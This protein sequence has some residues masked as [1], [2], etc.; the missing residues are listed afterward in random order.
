[1]IDDGASACITIDLKDFVGRSCRINQ[2]IKGV[3]GHAQATHRGT[4]Q[5]KIED[6]SG[7]VHSI[8]I[9]GT[10]Y[11]AGMPNQIFSPQHFAQVANDHNPK[12]EG[13]RSITNSKNITLFWGQRRYTKTILLDKNLNIGLTWSAPGSEAFT[14]YMPN[15]RVDGIQAFVSHLI[16]ESTDS[17]DNPSM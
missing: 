16:P 1:M 9:S 5:W 10:Y 17:D 8:N 2:R 7:K 12:P 4:V 3:A 13:T 14:A 15:D 6:D 11:M